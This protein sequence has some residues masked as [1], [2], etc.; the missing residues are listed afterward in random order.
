M[1][2]FKSE[3]ENL[4]YDKKQY[5][6]IPFTTRQIYCI[7]PRHFLNLYVSFGT[8]KETLYILTTLLLIFFIYLYIKTDKFTVQPYYIFKNV[9]KSIHYI[10]KQRLKKKKK[11]QR[12]GW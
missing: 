11:K 2:L 7:H 1:H 9:D 3:W 12:Y 10:I 6:L 4:K 5:W 8:K